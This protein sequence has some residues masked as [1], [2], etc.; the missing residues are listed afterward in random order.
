MSPVNEKQQKGISK[1]PMEWKFS[2][3]KKEEENQRLG[4]IK[5]IFFFSEYLIAF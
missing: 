5:T 3:L 4:E 2:Y 1:M